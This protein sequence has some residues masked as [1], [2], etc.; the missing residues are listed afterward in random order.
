MIRSL[1]KSALIFLNVIAIVTFF[2]PQIIFSA[3][4]PIS[5]DDKIRQGAEPIIVRI[6]LAGNDEKQGSG[7]IVDRQG[8]TYTVLTSWH[9]VNASGEYDV[10]TSRGEK[11]TVSS[12]NVQRIGSLDLAELKFTSAQIYQLAKRGNSNDIKKY[13]TLYVAGWINP[14]QSLRERTFFVHKGDLVDRTKENSE[15]YSL[16]Y[17]LTNPSIGTSGGAVLDKDGLLIGI[18]GQAYRDY[19]TGAVGTVS[20]IPINKYAQAKKLSIPPSKFQKIPPPPNYT[21]L[22]PHKILTIQMQDIEAEILRLNNRLP[23]LIGL[24]WNSSK[25]EVFREAI[26]NAYNL[27]DELDKKIESFRQ[28]TFQSEEKLSKESYYTLY[29]KINEFKNGAANF[30]GKLDNLAISDK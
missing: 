6:D 5:S 13:E 22:P 14:T 29:N 3:P 4:E 24:S 11:Y 20:A 7:V 21:N 26:L 18:N 19:N 12:N 27:C 9:V 1:K 2:Q 23:A 10:Q 25:K 17:S 8:T 28:L 30:R 16:V 15:G